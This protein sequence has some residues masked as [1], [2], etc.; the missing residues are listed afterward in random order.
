MYYYITIFIVLLVGFSIIGMLLN[1]ETDSSEYQQEPNDM[2]SF[3]KQ[4]NIKK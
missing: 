4:Q 3:L 2:L 1:K